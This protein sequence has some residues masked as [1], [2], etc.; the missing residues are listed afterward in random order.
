MLADLLLLQLSEQLIRNVQG[1]LHAA[2]KLVNRGLGNGHHR[3]DTDI[4]DDDLLSVQKGEHNGR[5]TCFQRA[6]DQSKELI[7]VFR[8]KGETGIV[9]LLHGQMHG[10]R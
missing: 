6:L 7:A 1:K 9:H 4:V 3:L 5:I 10:F 2:S 8:S